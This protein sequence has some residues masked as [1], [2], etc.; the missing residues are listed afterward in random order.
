MPDKFFGWSVITGDKL[1]AFGSSIAVG[2]FDGDGQKDVAVGQSGVSTQFSTVSTGGVRIYSAP[3]LPGVTDPLR[4]A[5]STLIT[6][7][8]AGIGGTQNDARFGGSLAANDF[9]VDGVSDLAI[10][11]PNETV[12]GV[13]GSGQVHVIYGLAGTG[14]STAASSGHPAAQK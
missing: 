6:Q 14:L 8:T 10:G 9:N 2:D 11:A 12:N 4:S 7:D 1:K 13:A 5:D 3:G